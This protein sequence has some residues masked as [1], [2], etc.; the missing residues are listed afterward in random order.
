M[1]KVYRDE[2]LEEEDLD[3]EDLEE[4]DEDEDYDEEDDEEDYEERY[5]CADE[6]VWHIVP[7]GCLSGRVRD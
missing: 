5:R 4:D 3:E 2:E 1:R 6:P 7:L